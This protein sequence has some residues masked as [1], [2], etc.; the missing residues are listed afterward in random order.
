MQG[1]I[2]LKVS[3]LDNKIGTR[4]TQLDNAI[5]SQVI[6]GDKVMSAI[7][8]YSGGTRIDGKLLHITGQTQFDKNVIAK[9]MIQAGAVT[10]DNLQVKNLSTVSST[11][12]LLRSKATGARV[13]IQDNLITGFDDD[14]NPRIKLGC[15]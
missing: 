14:N 4:I 7:T 5:K 15:W 11:I 1:A 9:G 8:Q 6:D 3:N 12:G 13:E 2:D 10:A